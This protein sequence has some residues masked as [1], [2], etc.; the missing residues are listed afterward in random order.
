MARLPQLL[1]R[2]RRQAYAIGLGRRPLGRRGFHQRARPGTD[3][4]MLLNRGMW[5][6]RRILSEEWIGRMLDP[7]SLFRNYGYLWW[8]NTGSALYPS[9]RA[10][11]YYARGAGGNLTWSDPT[12][13]DVA[14]LRWT[15]PAAM[16][17]FMKKTMAALG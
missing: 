11:S 2:D 9:A 5:N 8:L 1:C 7:C 4:L 15:D 17:G 16:D 14:V 12:N 10:D 3:R 6:G 13:D